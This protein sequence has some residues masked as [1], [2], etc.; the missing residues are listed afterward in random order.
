MDVALWCYKWM[1]WVWISPG[2]VR[3]RAVLVKISTN[4]GNLQKGP[5]QIK[6]APHHR[7][8]STWAVCGTQAYY[9]YS[10]NVLFILF[11]KYN[12]MLEWN[13]FSQELT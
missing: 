9:Y 6:L 7:L 13:I 10:R 2:G 12:C 11:V 1:G 3:Y 5:T 4:A 8:P